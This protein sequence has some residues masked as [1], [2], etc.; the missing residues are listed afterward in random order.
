MAAN[1][2]LQLV[3]TVLPLILAGKR[4]I[5]AELSPAQLA[6]TRDFWSDLA[7][8]G[9]GFVEGFSMVANVAISLAPTLLPIIL[10]K[11][12]VSEQQLVALARDWIS[13][14]IYYA[15]LAGQ[16]IGAVAPVIIPIISIAG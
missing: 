3:P 13:D 4:D 1:V 10:G 8:F 9:A 14:A 15:G 12:D 2:A 16:V 11:R 6:M 5:A 7:D